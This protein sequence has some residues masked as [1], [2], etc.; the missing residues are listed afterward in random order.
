MG[1]RVEVR[2]WMGGEV[3]GDG[4]EVRLGGWGRMGG[5]AG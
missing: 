4:W 3:R 5:E 1:A 2:G